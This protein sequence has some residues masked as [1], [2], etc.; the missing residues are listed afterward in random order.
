MI[1]DIEK[2]LLEWKESDK[3][4][5]IVL[6]GA[7]QIGK[8]YVVREFGSK[9]FE[10]YVEV[11]LEFE[12]QLHACFASLDPQKIIAQLELTSNQDIKSG[13]TLLFIDEIQECPNALMALR[14]FKEKMP[15]LHVIAAG[16]LLEFVFNEPE[17][18]MPVGRVQLFHMKP[19]SFKEFL[20]ATGNDKLRSFIESVTLN[21]EITPAI[22]QKCLELLK[23]YCVLGGM[24]EVIAD[25]VQTQSYKASQDTQSIIITTYQN[26]FGKYAQGNMINHC[27]LIYQKAPGLVGKQFKY[28]HVSRDVQSREL[29]FALD[30]L[31]KATIL[32]VAYA[33]AA[34]GIPLN[35]NLNEK[36]MKLCF[37][38][39]GLMKRSS[40]LDI[41]LLMAEDITLVNDGQVAEQFVGQELLAYQDILMPPQ[42]YFW[43]R[44]CKSSSAEVDYVISVG[45]KIIP[46]EVKSGKSSKMKSL[47]LMMAEENIKR[48]VKLSNEAMNSEGDIISLPLYLT[49]ELAR[50]L[51]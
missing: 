41:E 47:R 6:R 50:L 25:Y 21:S 31:V 3:H 24:P 46:I 45:S 5:P 13:K 51:A 29:K 15:E 18:R 42:V 11:N 10:T 36:K 1:R 35:A 48:G 2:N 7:R 8:T 14:Y 26:D 39:I 9:H 19:L 44:D 22:H 33:T 49:S 30:K 16:S 4:I 40:Q 20:S 23:E 28:V 37:V 43:A 34:S 17:F 32:H 12:R 27:A 38:D